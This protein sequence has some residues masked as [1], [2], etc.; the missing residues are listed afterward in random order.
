M[1]TQDAITLAD[2]PAYIDGLK[3]ENAKLRQKATAYEKDWYEAKAQFGTAM[4]KQREK[5]AR[6]ASLHLRLVAAA[7]EVLQWDWACIVN[8]EVVLDEPGRRQMT[9]DINALREAL[10]EPRLEDKLKEEA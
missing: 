6:L 9:E 1:N 3:A 7:R 8:E 10:A 2:L 4:S 5:H